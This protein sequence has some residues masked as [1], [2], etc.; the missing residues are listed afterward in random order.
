MQ[1]CYH[2]EVHRQHIRVLSKIIF[3]L[4]QDGCIPEGELAP[5][6]GVAMVSVLALI[7]IPYK[8]SYHLHHRRQNW[9]FYFFDVSKGFGQRSMVPK[10]G[11]S[12]GFCVRIRLIMD[13]QV[14][15]AYLGTWTLRV[16]SLIKLGLIE[17]ETC[18][19]SCKGHMRPI[20]NTDLDTSIPKHVL[21]LGST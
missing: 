18:R 1:D 20:P 12:C 9:G 8:G 17:E 11:S 2:H 16:R 4:L 5:K 13:S 15:P 6:D 7:W 10:T 21:R 19:G 14:D 3:S